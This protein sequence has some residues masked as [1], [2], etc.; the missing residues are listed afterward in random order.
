MQ[1]RRWIFKITRKWYG[2]M[3]GSRVSTM[4]LQNSNMSG[5]WRRLAFAPAQVAPL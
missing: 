4:D 3:K 1:G 2:E 5:L